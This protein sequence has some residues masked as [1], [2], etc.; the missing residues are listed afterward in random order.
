MKKLIIIM[1]VVALA[2]VNASA[3]IGAGN[4]IWERGD[5]GSTWQEWDFNSE[6]TGD[7]IA[8]RF[9]NPYGSD[10]PYANVSA[11]WDSEYSEYNLGGGDIV[12][13]IENAETA[14]PY[15]WV[16]IQLLDWM[17]YED[18][19]DEYPV[20]DIFWISPEDY[21]GEESIEL[22]Y[23]DAADEFN[24]TLLFEI[25]PNPVWEEITISG[26]WYVGQVIVDTICIPEP[27]TMCLLGLG[28]LLLRRRKK[29]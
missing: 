6:V 7:Y 24:I 8:D 5:A 23:V 17:P 26:D 3:T 11:S 25:Q 21:F 22:V 18:N 12:L 2:A 28:G 13:S 19:Y 1:A 29:A 20:M 14:N 16:Q 9:D 4:R 10:F 27:A 15:K